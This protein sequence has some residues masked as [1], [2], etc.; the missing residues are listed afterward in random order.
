MTRTAAFDAWFAQA[1]AVPLEQIAERRGIR[2]FGKVDRCGPCPKCGGHDRFAINVAKQLFNC[3]GCGA[4]GHG[5]I[6]FTSWL[7]GIEAIPAAEQLN[8]EPPPEANGKD[9]TPEPRKVVTNKFIYQ[10]ESGATLF[11]VGRIEYQNQ[12]GSFVMSAEGKRKKAFSQWRPD[13]NNAGMWLACVKDVRTAPYRLPELI[14]A[15]GNGYTALIVEGE[16][17]VDALRKWNV[18]ATCCAGGAGKWKQE[19]SEFLRSAEVVILPDNDEAGRNHADIVGASLQGIAASVRV[20][21]L[22]DLPPK[23]DILDWI[24]AGGTREKL[25]ELLRQAKPWAPRT[26]ETKAEEL[27]QEEPQINGHDEYKSSPLTVAPWWR[28][29]HAIPRRQFLYDRHYIRKTVS[30]TI[31]AGGRAKTTRAAY[32]ALSMATGRELTSGER[33]FTPPL[34]VGMLNGEEDQDELD[35]RLAG[36]C[37]HYVITEAD[38]G[39]RLFAQ[40]VRKTPLRLATMVKNVATINSEAMAWLLAFVQDNQLDVLIIDPLVS[41]HRVPENDNGAMDLLVKDAFGVIADETNSA[42]EICHH[43]G[44]AKQGQTETAVEDSRGASALIWAARSARVLN[45]MSPEEANKLGIAEDQRRLH[46]RVANSKANMAPIGKAEWIKLVIE[47]LP[48]GDEI[49]C[50]SSWKPPDPFKGVST[51]D[52]VKC[53]ALTQTGAYRL[54]ARSAD[55]VGYMVAD[56]LKINVAHGGRERSKRHR[57]H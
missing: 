27:R 56:V 49:A 38:L 4:K 39:G 41:L 31:A 13:P 30:A 16:A 11:A 18:P 29:P 6:D 5:A 21:E 37:Q 2:L 9:R 19:H 40:S 52:M 17:K 33:L 14:E 57:P 54:D 51:A 36:T 34:R 26:E 55:W 44:K 35:R 23:G 45:F 1:R 48:N 22:P 53:R 12:D 7:D 46:I 10:N 42:V 25:D 28:D 15:I 50:A 20:L 47:I 43:S 32:D 8:G 3:R 24:K